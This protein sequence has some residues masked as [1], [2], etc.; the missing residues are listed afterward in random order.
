MGHI[1]RWIGALFILGGILLG[2]QNPL[3]PVW[4]IMVLCGTV[5]VLYPYDTGSDE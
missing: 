5:L 3:E 1:N 2:V 4:Y